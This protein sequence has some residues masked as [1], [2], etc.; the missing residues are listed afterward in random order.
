M[1]DTLTAVLLHMFVVAPADAESHSDSCSDVAAQ[2][3]LYDKL[4]NHDTEKIE[5]EM[6]VEIDIVE[7]DTLQSCGAVGRNMERVPLTEGCRCENVLCCIGRETVQ[8]LD[9]VEHNRLLRRPRSLHR[10]FP[11]VFSCARHVGCGLGN[12][13]RR[14]SYSIRYFLQVL[15]T[16]SH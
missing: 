15:G 3:V 16:S 10:I 7:V 12:L 11:P 2:I 13:A 1:V 9:Q 14:Q 6:E 5:I 8:E 4:L